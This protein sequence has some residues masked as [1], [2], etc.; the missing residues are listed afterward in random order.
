MKRI[1]VA[2]LVVI[3]FSSMNIANAVDLEDKVVDVIEVHSEADVTP[4]AD[5]I[6]YKYRTYN[7]RLQYRRWNETQGYWVDPEWITM[8]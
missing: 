7:G 8:S 2:I 3:M 1:I 5:V 6:I 4:R